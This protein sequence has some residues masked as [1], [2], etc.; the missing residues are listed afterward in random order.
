[1]PVSIIS[2]WLA[3]GIMPRLAVSPSCFSSGADA[4]WR[5]TC[6]KGKR[7]AVGVK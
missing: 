6:S 7:K 2:S 5:P 3:L 4:T 1:M